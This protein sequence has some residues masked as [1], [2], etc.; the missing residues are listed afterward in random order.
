MKLWLLL[1][2]L[3]SFGLPLMLFGQ[4]LD[5]LILKH[6]DKKGRVDIKSVLDA[7]KA[8]IYNQPAAV[9]KVVKN[10]VSIAERQKAPLALAQSYQFM[11]SCYFQVKAD[12]DS[13]SYYL[14]QAEELYNTLDTKEAT[15][16]KA[17]VFHNFG[18]IRQVN[19]EYAEAIDY[20]IQ[21]LKLFDETGDMRVRPYTLNN[22]STLYALAKD[23]RKAEKYAREC[24]ELSQ[25][26]DD[27]FMKAT[28]SIALSDALMEQ[29]RFD[30]ALPPLEV[31]L[32]Y[33]K[34]KNDPYKV[35]LY[36]LNYGNYLMD[37]KKDYP[38]AVQELEKAHQLAES[39]GDEWEIMRH[40][41]ALSEAYFAN[42]QNEKAYTSAH[43]ALQIGK[44]LESKDKMEIALSVMARVNAN[45][46]DFESAYQ[47]LHSAYLL[48]DTLFNEN[49]QQ[50]TAFLETMYQTE[51]K[52]LKIE[53][54]EKQRQLYIWLGIAGGVIMLIAL[55]FA[56]IRYR[57]AI[58]RRKLAEQQTIRLQQEKQLVAVQ[59]TLDGEAA[60]RTRLAKDLHDGLGS[61]L[62]VVKF[63]LPDMKGG[64]ILESVDV[65]R[66]KMALGMLDDSIQELRRVA[67][68]MMPESLLRYGLKVS[69]SDFCTAI[70]I[71]DFHYFGDE[72]RLPEKL[73]IMIYR[74]IHELVN[75]ALK[76]AQATHI[77]V[78]LVQ[79][80]D[81]ISFTVQDDGVGFD[82]N[83][84]TEGM[85]LRN[86]RQRV[87]AF[88]GKLNIYSSG[89]GTEIH[90]EL[91]LTKK[92]QHD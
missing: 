31:A 68:H 17:M 87:E 65:S 13:A 6:T 48:K 78:Q 8:H 88:Q 72:A 41:S 84:V 89:Q 86:I 62:S 42:R 77:N 51:K 35:F 56:V 53:A 75:N 76:H 9:F 20:Y 22:I 25:Q 70:P 33:G 63:N 90:V 4:S 34:A 55:A 54:L 80:P 29:G 66:F 15:E 21:A 83:T 61:M 39:I 16:G 45:R 60:E 85:G 69:L 64:A 91:E 5:S 12:Y 1:V 92:E 24:I 27:E 14:H 23:Y 57:L 82:Q 32:E 52:E 46:R 7:S 38:L 81:R 30:E 26:A 2:A 74:C 3:S 50:Q 10:I 58:S 18:T 73:E 19:G 44:K 43:K 79:E 37:H 49:N 11:G 67:H 59:A 28:G 40:N 71:V 36:H 47:Q